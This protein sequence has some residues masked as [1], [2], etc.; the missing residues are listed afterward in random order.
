M[1]AT[2]KY[3]DAV[4]AKTGAPSDY[5][6]S[7]VLGISRQQISKYRTKGEYLGGE[8]AVKA[9]SI[10]EIDPLLILSEIQIDK[11]KTDGEKAAWSALFER[12]GGLELKLPASALTR[13]RLGEA[14]YNTA[15]S[16]YIML[17]RRIHKCTSY[18]L[19]A[20]RRQYA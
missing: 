5:A 14:S 4:K 2:N 13:A 20:D 1:N 11:S 7:V 9:A 16:L 10:L 8:T 18:L 6:L 15:E 17:N 19:I 3:L 12:C